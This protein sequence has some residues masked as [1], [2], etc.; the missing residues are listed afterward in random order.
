MATL[1][2]LYGTEAQAITLSLASLASGAARASTAVDNRTNLFLDAM[3]QLAIK[4]AA[5]G[6]SATGFF[7]IYAYG[8][9]NVSGAGGPL[10][11]DTVTGTDATITL[12]VPTNLKLLG[13]V[14]MVAV[15]TVYNSE[16]FSVASVFGGVLPE[17]WGVVVVN[18]SGA[19]FDATEGNHTKQY[20]GIYAQSV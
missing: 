3:V 14:N 5:A 17:E 8:T 16:P 4:S 15:A 10:W 13:V 9:Q 18:Q 19:A 6:V 20:Q 12:V 2:N 1:K 7:Q 11:P